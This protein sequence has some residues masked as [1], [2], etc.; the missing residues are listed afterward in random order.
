MRQ[1]IFKIITLIIL[2]PACTTK[3]PDNDRASQETDTVSLIR[4]TG[5]ERQQA[6]IKTG[7]LN[8]T[9]TGVFVECTGSIKSHPG[10]MA[11]VSVPVGGYI[12]EINF[13]TGNYVKKG[14]LLASLEHPDYIRLQ[15][16]FLESKSQLE[17]HREEYK[18]QGELAVENA[19]SLKKLQKAR[20]DFRTAEANY[21]SLKAQ[22]DYLGIN[23][24]SIHVDG[25]SPE[26]LLRAPIS[27]YIT[28]ININHGK[29]A[30][31]GEVICEITNNNR[32]HMKLLVPEKEIH[33]IA[34]GQKI[35]FTTVSD[36]TFSFEGIV[37]V[38][39][40][41]VDEHTR[42]VTVHGRLLQP[43]KNFIPG[44]SVRAKINVDSDSL[45]MVPSQAVTVENEVSFVYIKKENGYMRTTVHTGIQKGDMIE[46]RDPSDE[47]L[48]ADI[49]ISGISYLEAGRVPGK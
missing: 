34:Q 48:K 11:S 46:I 13:Y 43:D 32:L 4:I 2:L 14:E 24:D 10:S 19:A 36:T 9:E 44:M 41:I 15:Q 5:E 49:V 21:L 28:G 3:T 47:L 40:K 27:G 16:N 17:Y 42:Q 35:L 25:I 33:K 8:K 31:P 1:I 39:G 22:L 45:Y 23:T 37:T 38:T 6:G 7:K 12:K 20:A 26:V 18:R 29:Y 30:G